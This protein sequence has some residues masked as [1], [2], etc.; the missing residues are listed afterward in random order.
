MAH[1]CFTP[2]VYHTSLGSHE[3][4][5]RLQPGDTVSTT[6]VDARGRDAS[7]E[8]VTEPGN[9]MT[10]PFYIEGAEPGDTLMVHLDRLYPNRS[11]GWTG[12]AVAPNVLDP[13]FSYQFTDEVELAEW[14]IDLGAGTAELAQPSSSP[15]RARAIFSSFE[16]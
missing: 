16:P 7:G 13:G 5:L 4:V 3:P 8:S 2:Q 12:T 6:T 10:G 15:L 14:S 11:L 9:P 1:H